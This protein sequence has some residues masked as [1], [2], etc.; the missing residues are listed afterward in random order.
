M[1]NRRPKLQIPSSKFQKD[2]GSS[3]YELGTMNFE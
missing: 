3:N 1:K 2:S